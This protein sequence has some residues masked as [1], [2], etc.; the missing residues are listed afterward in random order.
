MSK[1]TDGSYK[2]T[3]L[4]GTA[5]PQSMSVDDVKSNFKLL[6][7]PSSAAGFTQLRDPKAAR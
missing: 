3:S 6:Q 4:D 5:G 1:N 2:A 7:D